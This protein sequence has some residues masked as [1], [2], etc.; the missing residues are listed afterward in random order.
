MSTQTKTF[1]QRLEAA[2]ARVEL[3]EN[4]QMF[5][6][7][8]GKLCFARQ[9]GANSSSLSAICHGNWPLFNSR[10][11]P[12]TT[13][14]PIIGRGPEISIDVDIEML[15]SKLTATVEEFKAERVPRY[16]EMISALLADDNVP[17][18]VSDPGAKDPNAPEPEPAPEPESPIE[19][20]RMLVDNNEPFF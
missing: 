2:R 13:K 8:I 5:V 7:A 17:Y 19:Q 4:L 6:D 3:A 9:K 16:Q 18:D 14:A 1:D 10:K 12:P 15:A 20:A 11:S